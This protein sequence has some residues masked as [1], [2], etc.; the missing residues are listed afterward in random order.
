[1]PTC[2]PLNGNSRLPIKSWQLCVQACFS[3]INFEWKALRHSKTHNM[4]SFLV[5]TCLHN[6][7]RIQA[8]AV[9]SP[10]LHQ[11]QWHEVCKKT[12]ESP[13]ARL[14]SQWK[15]NE[16]RGIAALPICSHFTGEKYTHNSSKHGNMLESKHHRVFRHSSHKARRS[17]S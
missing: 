16:K 4:V 10:W 2:R 7:V 6:C 12:S 11:R 13:G 8:I 3:C 17:H 14:I 5:R 9:A 1:M 15:S